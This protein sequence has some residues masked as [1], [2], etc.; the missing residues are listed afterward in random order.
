MT[1]LIARPRDPNRY[2]ADDLEQDCSLAA[3]ALEAKDKEIERLRGALEEIAN[4][5]WRGN[6]PSAV[7][8]ARAA[9]AGEKP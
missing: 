5:D 7:M 6:C 3:D 2:K 9:L 4:Q 1:D 8:I